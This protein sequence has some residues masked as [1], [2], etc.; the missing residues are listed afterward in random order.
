MNDELSSKTVA[1]LKVI[2]KDNNLPTSGLK[3]EII[4]RIENHLREKELN[5]P[6]ETISLEEDIEEEWVAVEERKKEIMEAEFV[7]L[8][9]SDEE[10]LVAEVIEADIVEEIPEETTVAIFEPATLF[11]Q[12]KT[13]KVAAVLLSILLATGGWYWY[14][15]NQLEPFTTDD[16]RY[17]DS[18]EFTVMNGDLDATEGFVDIVLD[19]FNSDEDEEEICRINL[20]FSGTGETSV[21]DGGASHLSAGE[22]D[23][24]GVVGA[25]GPL[26]LDWLTVE[27]KSQHDFD[28][29]FIKRHKPKPFNSEEC[30]ENGAGI[31]GAFSLSTTMWTEISERDVIATQADW[32][33]DLDGELHKGTAMSYG[34]GGILGALEHVVPGFAIIFSP[35]EVR[36]VFGTELIQTG[37]S[38]SYLNWDWRVVG[39]DEVNGEKMWR[40]SLE[41]EEISDNCLGFARITIW[42]N[43][44]SPWAIKQNVEIQISGKEGDRSAC[45]GATQILG[46]MLLPEGT[47]ELSL[48]MIQTGLERGEKLLDLGRSYSLPNDSQHIPKS[49]QLNSWGDNET[50]MPDQ[51]TLR[52]YTLEDAVSCI[53]FLTDAVATTT[54]FGDNDAYVWRAL[55]DRSGSAVQWNLSWVSNDPNSGWINMEISGTPSGENCT[56]LAHGS[57][58]NTGSHNREEIPSSLNISML[59]SDLTD[60]NRFPVLTGSEGFF[61]TLGHYH[62][63]TRVGHLVVTPDGDYTDW[64]NQ[65]QTGDKG[66]TTLDLSRSWDSD[67][68]SNSLTLAMDATTGQVIGW[69][70]YQTPS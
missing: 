59:E 24:I 23:L 14:V 55:D 53:P 16:L 10:L 6:E 39:P 45:G 13:P 67:G 60:N 62:P 7:P 58:E 2:C 1:K 3:S 28:D 18:M 33:L 49:S 20:T 19:N 22:E 5:L 4:T 26:G 66:A 57:H 41:H 63:E 34:V 46:D 68:W 56:Y 15:N 31:P 54:A 12:L 51:S 42:V 35:V 52:D 32:D 47:F 43:E 11:D 61:T 40:V 38:G 69:N 64:I 17:G 36:E 21:T 70:L 48:E 44:D 65:F 8:P 29:M 27:K 9:E 37:A 25:K 50:H 30:S